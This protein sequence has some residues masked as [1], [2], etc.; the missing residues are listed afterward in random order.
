MRRPILAATMA[1]ALGAC[2]H[3][4]DAHRDVHKDDADIRVGPAMAHHAPHIVAVKSNGDFDV[5]LTRLK[6]AIDRRG[7][8]T[9]AVIDHAK[10]AASIDADLRPTTLVIFGNP[11]GGTPL[12][13]A[14][15]RLGLRLPLKFLV[16]E[17]ADGAVQILYPDM[18]HLFHE[19]GI[20]EMTG[21]LSKIEGALATMADEAA[22]LEN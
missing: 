19:Y 9:F 2:S 5:T 3:A 14:E 7:F 17:D 1:I 10:G 12:M 13:Q 20:E 21:P 15:Q 16:I 18:A 6:E 22:D 8:K 11:K 4:Q